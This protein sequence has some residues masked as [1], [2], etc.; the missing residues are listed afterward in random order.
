MPRFNGTG[1]NGAGPRTGRG[2]GVCNNGAGYRLGCGF[3]FGGGRR[4]AI[5]RGFF[6]RGYGNP[7]ISDKE[8][9]NNQINLAEAELNELKRLRSELK[10]N[11]E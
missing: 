3:G 7:M 11:E 1:P 6:G 4:G 2:M 9:L 8:L 5:G 10:D